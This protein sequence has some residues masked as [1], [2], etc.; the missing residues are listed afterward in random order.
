V[1]G[2]VLL[3]GLAALRSGRR[4]SFTPEESAPAYA[5]ELSEWLPEVTEVRL[6]AKHEG[7][8]VASVN[9]FIDAAEGRA[10]TLTFVETE[11]GCSICGGYLDVPWAEGSMTRDPG[12]RSFIFTLKNHLGM[13]P[14]KFAQKKGGDGAAY[15]G[16]GDCF[17]FGSMEGFAIYRGNTILNNGCTYEAP[18]H[19]TA[20]FTGDGRGVFRAA[21]WELWEVE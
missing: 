4:I 16:R 6:V 14:K 12:N 2:R 7:R 19:G 5:E 13:P 3:G 17:W 20:L 9:A 18:E 15:M 11:N 8:D 10:K 1:V 21:R